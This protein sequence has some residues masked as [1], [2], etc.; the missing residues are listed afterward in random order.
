MG[1]EIFATIVDGKNQESTVTVP[2]PVGLAVTN[3]V[4]AVQAVVTNLD[5]LTSG[6]IVRCGITFAVDTTGWLLDA[7]AEVTSDVQEKARF[8][9][10]VV[11][12]F[13]KSISIPAIDDSEIIVAGSDEVDLTDTNVLA[14]VNGM[15]AGYDLTGVGGTGTAAPVDSRGAD[16]TALRDARES[17]GKTRG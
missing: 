4:P 8:V 13:V 14:F 1:L 17:W 11:G 3:W 10:D 9:F 5:K 12:G 15:T 2:M 6:K 7:V 16:I